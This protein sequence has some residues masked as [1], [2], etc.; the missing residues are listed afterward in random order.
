MR[1]SLALSAV[2]IRRVT[3]TGEAGNLAG[4]SCGRTSTAR[5]ASRVSPGRHRQIRRPL[6]AD[7]RVMPRAIRSPRPAV[8]LLKILQRVS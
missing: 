1:V 6:T 7:T 2:A 5:D 8:R 4:P 3:P